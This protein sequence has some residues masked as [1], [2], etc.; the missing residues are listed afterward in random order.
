MIEMSNVRRLIRKLTILT[1]GLFV[2]SLW[3]LYATEQAAS[4]AFAIDGTA[5]QPATKDFPG[6]KLDR[7]SSFVEKSINIAKGEI[8]ADIVQLN[9]RL[10]CIHLHDTNTSNTQSLI[11]SGYDFL[12]I[13]FNDVMYHG[14]GEVLIKFR[15][16]LLTSI[17]IAIRVGKLVLIR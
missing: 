1:A 8:E 11:V 17:T 13:Y 16:S 4:Q 10:Y 14:Q 6:C 5:F 9:E 15:A 7:P 12:F 3:A 2:L